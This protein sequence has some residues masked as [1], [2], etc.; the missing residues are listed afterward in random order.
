MQEG[1]PPSAGAL[2]CPA[3]LCRCPGQVGAVCFDRCFPVSQFRTLATVSLFCSFA[4]LQTDQPCLFCDGWMDRW[5]QVLGHIFADNQGDL[6]TR[7]REEE[8]GRTDQCDI[9]V[10]KNYKAQTLKVVQTDKESFNVL[11]VLLC[12]FSADFS[13]IFF[14]GKVSTKK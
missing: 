3:L 5:V 14:K 1:R 10:A 8:N 9:V 2:L 13:Q 11:Q 7:S 4:V 6:V 12:L